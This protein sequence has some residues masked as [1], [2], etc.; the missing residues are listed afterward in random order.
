MVFCGIILTVNITAIGF[1]T[2]LSQL[3]TAYG[4]SDWLSFVLV[5]QPA[6]LYPPFSFVGSYFFA[7][8][9]IHYVLNMAMALILLGSWVRSLSFAGES[10]KF[11][12]LF[13]GQMMIFMAQPLVMNSISTIANIWFADHER[14]RSTAFSGTMN[15]IGAIV[16]LVL[17]GVIASGVD[18]D[19]PTDCLDRLQEIVL[20][21]NIINTIITV[22]FFLLFREKPKTPPSKLASTFS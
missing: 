16:G 1:S 17:T 19:S 12:V 21:Q 9:P 15:P 4:V 8:F 20:A 11:W 2:Y 22:P 6:L 3:Q 7:R 14:A 13:I 5:T 10:P 18:S